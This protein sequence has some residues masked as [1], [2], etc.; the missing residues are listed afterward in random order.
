MLFTYAGNTSTEWVAGPFQKHPL[1]ASDTFLPLVF[2]VIATS[3]LWFNFPFHSCN[4]DY[5]AVTA[6]SP[7]I[8]RSASVQ[9]K[10]PKPCLSEVNYV[11]ISKAVSA[12][13]S[14]WYQI[15]DGRDTF[16]DLKL[17]CRGLISFRTYQLK[18]KVKIQATMNERKC[19][20]IFLFLPSTRS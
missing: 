11:H 1:C 6:V 14:Y 3:N 8:Q 16:Q 13:S 5:K 9:I 15:L 10:H 4:C 20:E 12:A 17:I 2:I 7:N 18:K 19:N